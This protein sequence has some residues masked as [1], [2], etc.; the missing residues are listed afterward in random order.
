MLDNIIVKLLLSPLALLYG[1]GISLR[2]GMYTAGLI[3]SVK[4]NLPVISVGNLSVGG[5]GKTPHIEY[6]LRLL[7]HYIEVAT[8]SRGYKRNT[9]G[10]LDVLAEHDASEVGDEPL[11]FSRKFPDVTVTVC[12]NRAYGI[13]QM[14]GRHPEIQAILLD[15]AFQHRAVTPGLNIMLTEYGRPF[16]KDFLLPAGR[17]REWRSA[18]RRADVLIVSKCPADLTLEQKNKMIEQLAPFAHQQVFFTQYVYGNPYYMFNKSYIK[19]LDK[20]TD[21]QLLSAIAGTDYLLSYLEPKVATVTSQEYADH[22]NFST[23]DLR[24]IRG[25]FLRLDSPNKI[26]VTTEKDAMRLEVHREY[27]QQED[28]PIFVLPIEVAFLFD[29]GPKFDQLIQNYLLNFK[30]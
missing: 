2:N 3:R 26:I 10:Y 20:D 9:T 5:A 21:V 15:D 13:P 17:L 11:Q 29:E 1:L 12:E 6:L 14:V 24:D 23:E 18:Y 8:L 19:V 25:Q 7:H 4:F 22:H 28:L 30:V 27:I 16:F